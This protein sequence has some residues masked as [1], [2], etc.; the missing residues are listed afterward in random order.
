MHKVVSE[1][2]HINTQDDIQDL[3]AFIKQ[4]TIELNWHNVSTL[5]KPGQGL[6]GAKIVCEILFN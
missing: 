5:V 2:R 3:V 1:V 6:E 4:K